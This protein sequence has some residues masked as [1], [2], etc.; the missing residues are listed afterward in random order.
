MNRT[1]IKKTSPA[2]NFK[3]NSATAKVIFIIFS[4][5]NEL[6][7]V[8]VARKRNFSSVGRVRRGGRCF[9]LRN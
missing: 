1:N 2:P 8:F 4:K 7:K 9:I 3:G 5:P 6:F